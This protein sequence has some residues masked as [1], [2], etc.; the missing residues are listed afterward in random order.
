MIIWI[1]YCSIQAFFYLVILISFLLLH[2]N[3]KLFKYLNSNLHTI[4][5]L[6]REDIYAGRDFEWRFDVLSSVSYEKI[7]FSFWRSV[8]RDITIVGWYHEIP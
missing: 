3:K 6:S 2:R 4:G 8:K 5:E 1:I 7:L